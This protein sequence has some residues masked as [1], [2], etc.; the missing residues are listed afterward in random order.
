MNYYKMKRLKQYAGL[1]TGLLL[2]SCSGVDRTVNMNTIDVAGAMENLQE[3]KVSQLG[4]KIRFVPLET[5]D[6][7]LVADH[8]DFWVTDKYVIVSNV[9]RGSS[10]RCMTFDL[11]TGKYIAT[12]GHPGQDPEAYGSS[13]PVLDASG[14]DVL[15]FFKP[16]GIVKYNMDG[17]FLGSINSTIMNRRLTSYPL[18]NDTVM[19][20]VLSGSSPEGD[21]YISFLRMNLEGGLIDSTA[22]VT[23]GKP[24]DPNARV[25]YFDAS[26]Q[27]YPSLMPYSG[28]K[29]SRIKGRREDVGAAVEIKGSDQM[30]QTDGYIRFHQAFNDSIY[31]MTAENTPVAYVFDT[32]KWRYPVEETG[33]TEITSDHVFVTD[34]TETTDKIVFAVSNGWFGENNKGYV[35]LYDKKT[36]A[37][38]MSEIEKGFQDDLTGFAPFYPVRTNNKG[39]LVGVMTIED[40]DKW[41]EKHPGAERPTFIETLVEDANPVLVIVE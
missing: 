7:V 21:R 40:I 35:G 28:L 5:S 13:V 37:T 36:G 22:V 11:N 23:Q 12:I 41:L 17:R 39:Q 1:L 38:A 2:I 18:I 29:Y 32:G 30:W 8:W 10:Q 4:S 24:I 9:G 34:M 26:I 16:T 31:D 15:Y 14:N 3:L 25:R 19:T 6:S 33:K 27:N 20:T